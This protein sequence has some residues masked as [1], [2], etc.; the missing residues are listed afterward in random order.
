MKLKCF[1]IAREIIAKEEISLDEAVQTVGALKDWILDSY[2]EMQKVNGFMIAVDHEYANDEKE[3]T[4][5]SE[6][7]I[8]PPVSGG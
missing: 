4:A 8:I 3:I 7:A 2:P 5:N 6:I 1:G